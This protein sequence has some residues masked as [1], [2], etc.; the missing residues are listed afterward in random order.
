M[1]Q[2]YAT[3]AP[4]PGGSG[5]T[6]PVPG[7]MH[8]GSLYLKRQ[9]GYLILCSGVKPALYLL[10]PSAVAG[11]RPASNLRWLKNVYPK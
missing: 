3:C 8:Q 10:L 5:R 11:T 6:P 1:D 4:E 7:A 2:E 9:V